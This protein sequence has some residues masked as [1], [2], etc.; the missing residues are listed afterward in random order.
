MRYLRK[1]ALIVCLCAVCFTGWA[2]KVTVEQASQAA[3]RFFTA[4]SPSTKSS[5]LKMRLVGTSESVATK[6]GGDPTYYVFQPENGIGFVIMAAETGVRPII[7]YSPTGYVSDGEMPENL[8]WWLGEVDRQIRDFWN[9]GATASPQT[10]AMWSNIATKAT[11]VVEIETAIWGQN[12]PFNAQCPMGRSKQ[13]VAG[14]N[15]TATAIVMRYYKWPKSGK[16]KTAAYSCIDGDY[17][18]RVPERDLEHTY[19]WDNMPLDYNGVLGDKQVN[20]VATLI[21][22]LGA[23]FML[24]YGESSTSAAFDREVMHR[25]FSYSPSLRR[26]DRDDYDDEVWANIMRNELSQYRPFL[27]RGEK[28]SGHIF[29]VDGYNDQKMFRINWGWTGSYNG[30]Y[31]FDDLRP[32]SHDYS[33]KQMA[34]LNMVPETDSERVVD[35]LVT[36]A[37]G[38]TVSTK[39]FEKGVEFKIDTLRVYNAT[40]VAFKGLICVAHTDRNGNVKEW[41]SDEKERI[42]NPISTGT[43]VTYTKLKCVLKE[44]IDYGDRLM[45]FYREEGSD[46]WYQIKSQDKGCYSE[47]LLADEFD[48]AAST[49]FKYNRLEDKIRLDVKNGVTGRLFDASGAE[50]ASAVVVTEKSIIIDTA[51]LPLGEYKIVLTKDADSKEVRFSINK[52]EL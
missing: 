1:I 52:L 33:E 11:E 41:V 10:Q 20:A 35:H 7:G 6:S 37:P 40:A 36:R 46:K 19:D 2:E 43:I 13:T 51:A 4:C 18:I 23:A 3:S 48:I 39:A 38:I 22:D 50:K 24:S 17:T 25:N 30:Y 5:S 28:S 21:A 26:F 14:C 15:A 12:A 44:E 47:V 32:G 49:S 16:G 34:Y 31:S 8:V 45:A 42:E 27:Y 29:V 9:S